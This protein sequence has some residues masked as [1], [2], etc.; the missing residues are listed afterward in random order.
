MGKIKTEL[1]NSIKEGKWCQIT[2]DNT[3]RG[4]TNFW[5]FILDINPEKKKLK[6]EM[7]NHSISEKILNAELKFEKIISAQVIEFTDHEPSLSLIEK[8]QKNPISFAWLEFEKFNNNILLYLE[9]CYKLDNDPFESSYTM[10]KGLDYEKLKRE[11]KV[12]LDIKQI[13]S[14]IDLIKKNDFNSYSKVYNELSMSILSIDEGGKKFVFIYQNLAYNP[15]TQELSLNGPLKF[16]QNY[17]VKDTRHS[18]SNYTELSVAEFQKSYENDP[19]QTIEILRNNLRKKQEIDTRPDILIIQRNLIVPFNQIFKNIEDE[20]SE[21]NLNIPM[22]AFFGD[23]NIKDN[24]MSK[25]KIVLFD[26]RINADQMFVVY[27][28]MKNPV[29]YVQGPPGTGK[30]QTLFNVIVSGYYNDKTMLITSNNNIPVDGIIDKLS[31]EYNGKSVPFPYLRLGNQAKNIEATRK[32]LD[33]YNYTFQ[34]KIDQIKVKEIKEKVRSKNADLV[35]KLTSYRDLQL[36]KEKLKALLNVQDQ[37]EQ[38]TTD[39]RFKKAIANLQD[40]ISKTTEIKDEDLTNIAFAAK[41]DPDSQYYLYASSLTHLKRLRGAEYKDLIRIVS[42][43]DDQVRVREFNTWCSSDENMKL[44]TDVFPIIFTTNI[45]SYHLGNKFLFDTVIMDEAGQCA[46]AISLIPISK[47]KALLLVGDE[48]QLQPITQLLPNANKELKNKYKISNTYDYAEQSILTCMRKADN[49]SNKLL[50][51]H[52]YR[53][54]KN[55]I[56]FSNKYF[57]NN[58]L[59]IDKTTGPGNLVFYDCKT[60]VIGRNYWNQS[61]EEAQAI[62]KYLKE[63]GSDN[64][65]VITPFLNQQNLIKNEL[66]EAGLGNIEVSTIHK[67]QGA[68]AKTVILST[69]VN[70]KTNKRIMNWLESHSEIANVAISRAK[71]NFVLIGDQESI[72][73]LSS[74]NGIWKQLFSYTKS[75]GTTTVIPPSRNVVYGKSNGSMN[76]KEFYKTMSQLV[77]V[78]EKLMIKR[79]VLVKDVFPNDA[80]LKDYTG[81]FDSVIMRRKNIL[82]KF[83]TWIVFEFDGG[84][85]YENL[86]TIKRD[87]YKEDICKANNITLIRLPNS[88]AKDYTFILNIIK[89]YE[90]QAIDESEEMQLI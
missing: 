87:K 86:D 16:N 53:C 48:D 81:E 38:A 3:E 4:N 33:L 57:Y 64:T 89:K 42:I 65:V 84:E 11:K 34:D 80:S 8:I 1:V 26:S 58:Q 25:P 6:V 36:K 67:M 24:G 37:T 43:A 41:R 56:N 72:N 83:K 17:S 15:K 40:E 46:L 7:Y 51:K 39:N 2:Y 78:H 5:I 82:S 85:H 30:T 54:G 35:E 49:I 45:S 70:P 31:F 21:G 63:K 28:A 9:D 76:E 20:A 59:I 19:I 69:A 68:E 75:N 88:Y 29:T 23:I 52:H 77:S 66:K 22:R 90:R 73:K 62:I 60:N 61:Y 55:I 10:I 18:L 14:V 13:D 12:K 71:Q 79:N 27:C 74:E 50:L 47:A 44:L 32:I